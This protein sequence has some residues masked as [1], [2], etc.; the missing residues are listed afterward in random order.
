MFRE[1]AGAPREL[2]GRRDL[3]DG[4]VVALQPDGS[5]DFHALMGPRRAGIRL[6]FMAFDVLHVD[7]EHLIDEPYASRRRAL[8][9][10]RLTQGRWLTTPSLK[11]EAGAARRRGRHR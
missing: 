5:Q 2:D 9:E 7:G 6:A 8:E 1:L 3:L 10:L 4:E 11:N